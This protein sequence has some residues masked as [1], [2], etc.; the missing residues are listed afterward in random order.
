MNTYYIKND[1]F[2]G[3]LCFLDRCEVARYLIMHENVIESK[4][5]LLKGSWRSGKLGLSCDLFSPITVGVLV[6]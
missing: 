4:C 2:D 3:V 6:A 1:V 5:Q